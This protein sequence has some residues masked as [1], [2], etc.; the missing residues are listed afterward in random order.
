[1]HLKK[2]GLKL[3]QCMAGSPTFLKLQATSCLS[4]N[5]KGY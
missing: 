4:I 3:K 5:A 1:M 2:F